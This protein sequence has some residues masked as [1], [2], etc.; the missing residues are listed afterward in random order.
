MRKKAPH[1]R[2]P[3][4]TGLGVWTVRVATVLGLVLGS[5]PLPARD[6]L[7]AAQDDY[8]SPVSSAVTVPGVSEGVRGP[9]DPTAT[10]RII[11][12]PPTEDGV[13]AGGQA[14][15][16][17]LTNVEW[18]EDMGGD[19]QATRELLQALISRAAGEGRPYAGALASLTPGDVTRVSDTELRIALPPSMTNIAHS[20]GTPSGRTPE[21]RTGRT[22]PSAYGVPSASAVVPP[23]IPEDLQKIDR[24][25]EVLV[26]GLQ[27]L[28]AAQFQST[29]PSKALPLIGVGASNAVAQVNAS[30]QPFADLTGAAFE[31]RESLLAALEGIVGGTDLWNPGPRLGTVSLDGDG[32]FTLTFSKTVL[33]QVVMPS[34]RI[35]AE[36][37]AVS[38]AEPLA[39]AMTWDM[40]IR[41]GTTADGDFFVDTASDRL[42]LDL[43]IDQAVNLVGRLGFVDIEAPGSLA[44]LSGK[45]TL[46]L[47]DDG[48]GR[49]TL[50]ELEASSV[51]ALTDTR[52]AGTAR[53]EMPSVALQKGLLPG[54]TASTALHWAN[55]D[56][57][58]KFSLDTEDLTAKGLRRFRNVDAGTL[59][60]IL[61]GTAVFFKDNRRTGLLG[62]TLPLTKQSMSDLFDAGQELDEE[63]VRLRNELGKKDAKGVLKY[64]DPSATEFAAILRE[65]G[66]ASDG[67]GLEV[68]TEHIQY[69]LQFKKPAFADGQARP[70]VALDL[71]LGD[72]DPLALKLDKQLALT[73]ASMELT[74]DLTFG[75]KIKDRGELAGELGIDLRDADGDGTGLADPCG[76][77]S[78]PCAPGDNVDPDA[79]GDG[80]PD[81]SED[82]DDADLIADTVAKRPDHTCKTLA[83][84]ARTT[85]AELLSMNNLADEAAFDA[86]P[87]GTVL[88]LDPVFNLP[89]PLKMGHRGFLRPG[90]NLVT[91]SS[92]ITGSI[93][94]GPQPTMAHLGFL[95]LAIKGR[96]LLSPAFTLG[97]NDSSA[98][99]DDGK[100]DLKEIA[101]AKKAGQ[102]GALLRTSP[103]GQV[104]AHLTL[105]NP[106]LEGATSGGALRHLDIVGNLSALDNPGGPAQPVFQLG[107]TPADPLAGDVIYIGQDINE[108][109]GFKDITAADMLR[110]LDRLVLWLDRLEDDPVLDYPLPFI[111]RPVSKVASLHREFARFRQMVR[112]N[113]PQ[114][115]TSYDR[116]V[117][118]ALA[119]AGATGPVTLQVTEG[120]VR[121]T[122]PF[123]L[124]RQG[125]YPL[126]LLVP[127]DGEFN[128]LRTIDPAVQVKASATL[129]IPLTMGLRFDSANEPFDERGFVTESSGPTVTVSLEQDLYE[130]RAM[131][132]FVTGA[133]SGSVRM[134][135]GT[136][137][138]RLRDPDGDGYLTLAELLGGGEAALTDAVGPLSAIMALDIAGKPLTPVVVRGNLRA[139]ENVRAG[140]EVYNRTITDPA[141]VARI[142]PATADQIYV[143]PEVNLSGLL[144]DMEVMVSGFRDYAQLFVDVTDI[145]NIDLPVIGEAM[146]QANT[147]GKD[148]VS[149][150]DFL[151]NLL[152]TVQDDDQAFL[153]QIETKLEGFLNPAGSPVFIDVA[154]KGS[155]ADQEVVVEF[156]LKKEITLCELASLCD[157]VGGGLDLDPVFNLDFE[158]TP[159]VTVGFNAHIGIGVSKDDGFFV[160]GG[161]ILGLYAK[162]G[163][164]G[165]NVDANLLGFLNMSIKGG[166]VGV[167]GPYDSDGDGKGD[168]A[169]LGVVLGEMTEQQPKP[170]VTLISFLDVESPDKE[171]SQAD[172]KCKSTKGQAE[173]CAPPAPPPPPPPPG[174]EGGGTPFKVGFELELFA[175]L[176]IY[177]QIVLSFGSTPTKFPTI[178]STLNFKWGFEKFSGGASEV[179][180]PGE[181][182]GDDGGDP[183]LSLDGIGIDLNQLRDIILP[184][185]EVFNFVNP[186]AIEEIRS[187][188]TSEVPILNISVLDLAKT[189]A[190]ELPESTQP[191]KAVAQAAILAVE[192]MIEVADVTQKLKAAPPSNCPTDLTTCTFLTM[193]SV[194]ILPA[195]S[196]TGPT[197]DPKTPQQIIDNSPT[198]K[199]AMGSMMANMDGMN[200]SQLR[201]P[202][203]PLKF[204][205]LE[206]PLE[207]ANLLSGKGD[208]TFIELDMGGFPG[209]LPTITRNMEGEFEFAFENITGIVFGPSIAQKIT[210][211]DLDVVIASG[212]FEV[213]FGGC[214]CLIFRPG[215]GFD[216]RGLKEG[217]SFFDGLYIKD[218]RKP[219]DP[220]IDVPEIEALATVTAYVTGDLNFLGA[221]NIHAS[222]GGTVTLRAGVGLNDDSI[223]QANEDR[224]D[225][226]MHFDEIVAILAGSN[227][228]G[229][230]PP[231][232]TPAPTASTKYDGAG[233]ATV[234]DNLKNLTAAQVLDLYKGN[235]PQAGIESFA[236]LADGLKGLPQGLLTQVNVA[237][238]DKLG[239][240]LQPAKVNEAFTASDTTLTVTDGTRF[241]SGQTIEIEAEKLS[242]TAVSGNDLTVTRG[243]NSTTAAAHA[244]GTPILPRQKPLETL[245]TLVHLPKDTL[246][247]AGISATTRTNIV[248]ELNSLQAGSPSQLDS[249]LCS[250]KQN[251]PT[252]MF[253]QLP[254]ALQTRIND[255]SCAG[256][257]D[258]GQPLASTVP[259]PSGSLEDIDLARILCLFKFNAS[260]K[261]LV[262][263]N[264]T[265]QIDLFLFSINFGFDWSQDFTIFDFELKCDEA[266]QVA[267]IKNGVLKPLVGPDAGKRGGTDGVDNVDGNEVVTLTGTGGTVTVTING[268]S[269]TFSGVQRIEIN[270]GEGNDTIT[271]GS[272]LDVP[273]VLDGG[274]GDDILGGGDADDIIRG[275][276]GNDTIR[277]WGGADLL[278]GNEGNDTIYGG[279][280]PTETC[281]SD[282]GDTIY[283]DNENGTGSGADTLSGG[284]GNDVIHGGGGDD[285]IVGDDGDDTLNGNAGNDTINGGAGVD[286]IHGHDGNDVLHGNA[287]NDVIYGD[288]GN[289]T[290]TGDEDDDTLYGN[291]GDDN[292]HGNA[293]NDAIDGGHGDDTLFGDEDDDNIQGGSGND[294]IYGGG[295][296]DTL[297]GGSG[298][299]EIEGQ[300]GDDTIYGGLGVDKLKGGAGKDT[301]YGGPD[302]DELWGDADDDKLYGGSGVD[303]LYGGLGNDYLEGNEDSDQLY[304]EDGDDDLIGG[305]SQAGVADKGDTLDGGNGHDVIAGDNATITRPGGTNPFDGSLKRIIT[306]LDVNSTDAD[307]FGNDQI[308]GGAG[309]DILYGGAGNDTI[310][311][312]SQ[313]VGGVITP[314]ANGGDDIIQ[315]N[316]GNDTIYGEAGQDDI[317]GGTGRTKSDDPTTAMN[318]RLDGNDIIYGGNSLGT[319]GSVDF[320]VIAGDNADIQRSTWALN[321]WNNGSKLRVFTLYDIGVV[322]LPAGA[323]TYG[324]DHIYG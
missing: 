1:R 29:S 185:L 183:E 99:A 274:P 225:G 264:I 229:S 101:A 88:K 192:L 106:L 284:L 135:S 33:D 151:G 189:I 199:A 251:L 242:I 10:V 226:K 238:L 318:G 23:A 319:V 313:L 285:T 153:A 134:P 118:S 97:L 314:V 108:L 249:L 103:Q 312:D 94:E 155:I 233:E 292:I 187:I 310:Y 145:L 131:F 172:A 210:L 105:E 104:D 147:V 128:L 119:K 63:V 62:T 162:V 219:G 58:D 311:G 37:L 221:V 3:W 321:T 79:D 18:P 196:F 13:G 46:D 197:G 92:T 113:K 323:G 170:R 244:S 150:A 250:L 308:T 123:G 260:F 300:D 207:L 231:P 269:Q 270:G 190:N 272:P 245:T 218:Y 198:V 109:L 307:L 144:L 309:N 66:L 160:Q 248:T 16:I 52:L 121:F 137:T 129:A 194:K 294:K 6:S 165:I 124:T 291:D 27:S 111:D 246:S 126:N 227:R 56:A 5:L 289:D 282:G 41:F 163:V 220:K 178:K 22:A 72:D 114:D 302:N 216:S 206:N 83:Y 161:R 117:K 176:P 280:D 77:D 156:D 55:I 271:R 143:D 228:T 112:D 38:S 174:G 232:T 73:L 43:G 141:I 9:S 4:T 70:Q 182:P 122:L 202:F 317:V 28:L 209:V 12:T 298:N 211:F 42:S 175:E 78:Q 60:D 324:N 74:Y 157:P 169:W 266:Q 75:V 320:D 171:D 237:A 275:G 247:G 191:Y 45:F 230:V 142:D 159:V 87:E 193:G 120:D 306:L 91:L 296:N 69:R 277:G 76:F 288:D 181:N 138:V 115:L 166:K 93:G 132:K 102:F 31:S 268:K 279:C 167:G 71:K 297:D 203:K 110:L 40:T 32:N 201:G 34:H 243:A 235:T 15:A 301:I 184:P 68:T 127:R 164:D 168:A 30:L 149:A 173:G 158:V 50:K 265:A 205:F 25:L 98:V 281:A 217:H 224:N 267:R 215:I 90:D 273:V 2:G 180:E 315:G 61:S 47:K 234:P 130:T 239:V 20:I 204:P 146:G 21:D 64:R 254:A 81:A 236:D 140:R 195:F 59:L 278:V 316:A 116:Y 188:V 152:K 259:A 177:S 257:G 223:Y 125:E 8:G 44:A 36:K 293:G 299:D 80:L 7:A 222:G 214:L 208:A 24:G 258:G 287:G 82:D 136:L 295:G 186:M 86:L 213:G 53:L 54:V 49:T 57:P 96:I 85:C 17:Q 253:D 35:Y 304:G 276:P 84:V 261:G 133:V 256:A 51:G 286:T 139:L 305:T 283:G 107:P 303:K 252:S 14:I 154:V 11:S 212:K 39:L 26:A 241:K 148:L 19:T 67:A 95:D 48:D 100:V 255:K 240:L 179:P 65:L 200:K 322:G 262:F 290:I 263:A 89:S